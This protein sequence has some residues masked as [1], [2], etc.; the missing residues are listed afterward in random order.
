MSG[1]PVGIIY[2]E[3]VWYP[4]LPGNIVNAGTFDF[5]VRLQ[6]V[7][8]LGVSGLIGTDAIDASEAVLQAC[9]ELQDAG[10]RAVSAA[11]GFFGRYQQQIAAKLRVPT[12]LS[13]LV[14][15]PWIQAM[16]PGRRVAVLT[17]DA[18]SLDEELLVA[19]GVTNPESLIIA[20]LQDAP[21]FSAILQGR[22]EFDNELVREE[23][24]A[25]ARQV[26]ADPTVGAVLLE[27]SDMPPYAAAVQAAVGLPV[28][29]FVTLI[30]WLHSAVAQRPYAG[31]I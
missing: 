22:G 13:S 15:L 3:Q 16:I 9:E 11:C 28:F 20:G 14:Q 8:G 17:A 25:A 30:R 26:C 29:D 12:A 18:T 27:C 6:P 4:M 24:V 19:C 2:I 10:V 7:R 1:Y 23:V 5:P 21:E 31:W